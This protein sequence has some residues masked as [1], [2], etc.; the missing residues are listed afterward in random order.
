MPPSMDRPL[1]RV[2]P[3]VNTKRCKVLTN[4]VATIDKSEHAVM[5]LDRVGW[6][7]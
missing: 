2:L 1:A 7:D 4:Y 3:D 5:V 6:H